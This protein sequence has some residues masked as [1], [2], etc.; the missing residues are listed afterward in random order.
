[1]IDTP[2]KNTSYNLQKI[3]VTSAAS[4]TQNA[5]KLCS[6]L[7]AALV[8]KGIANTVPLLH[9]SQ[10]CS[11]YIRRY[12]ISHFKEPVDIACSNFG[13][14]T[15]IFGG[16]AN[17]KVALDNIRKQYDPDF[18]GI[19]TTCLAETIGDDVPMFLK[20]YH[21]IHKE[22]ILPPIVS[23]ATPS[24]QGTHIEGFHAAVR[25]VV[26]GLAKERVQRWYAPFINLFPG[27]IS[28][29]DL[30]HL[31]EIVED[32]GLNTMML[33]DYSETLDGGLWR[34]YQRI[35]Q[36]GTSV[37]QIKV[38][39]S[40]LASI[41]FGRCLALSKNTAGTVLS[42]RFDT[43]C[44]RTGLPMGIV[45]TDRFM[46]TL[47]DL[48]N[49]PVPDKYT[50]QRGRLLDA[51]VDAHKV[52]NGVRAAI[53]GEPDLVVGL[54]DFLVEIGIQPVVCGT[55]M[56]KS[57]LSQALSTVLTQ[58]QLDKASVMEDVDFMDMESVIKEVM[59]DILIGNS[60]G[61][62][63]SRRLNI[64]LLRVGFPIH[65]RIGGNRLQLLGYEGTQIFFDRIA[66]T[67]MAV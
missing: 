25:A 51:M 42:D 12:V 9:G 16:G 46:Q 65:D 15:A 49:R 4:A 21:D 67:L 13:E 11:T 31:K 27:M 6:P 55:G 20:E 26:E 10:G 50:T 29:A 54:V 33:P 17:L 64:P 23:V 38:A 19:A 36:G 28:P 22:E 40:A 57:N 47:S 56:A 43:F 45:Q 58:E 48:S 63:M 60:K 1:M 53:F 3:T 66:N 5:C 37:E 34:D 30:R 61:Y 8:F 18:I 24:Y 7:G 14:Q 41:E 52:V 35:P 2:T 62:A 39:G 32:F 44:Q 59:P